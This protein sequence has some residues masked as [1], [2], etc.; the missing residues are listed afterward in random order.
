MSLVLVGV[1]AAAVLQAQVAKDA[2]PK[3][4]DGT[5]P[6][7][8]L[9]PTT[10]VIGASIDAA[11]DPAVDSCG[12]WNLE[13]PMQLRWSGSDATSGLAG[14][15]V[16]VFGPGWDY[17]T[18]NELEHGIS[19]T[20]YRFN[21]SNYDSDCGGGARDDEYWVV[22][23]DNRG[24]SARS[25]SFGQRI[26]VWQENGYNAASGE[27]GADGL[28]L[29]S[30]SGTWTRSNCTCFNGGHTLFSTSAGAALTYT[31]KV[32]RPGQTIGLAM[33]KNTNRGKADISVD[34]G[35]ATSVDTYASAA[36]HRVIVWQK[37]LS[38][39]THTIKVTNAGTAGRSRID[40]D[41]LLGS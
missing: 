13:V 39:G 5:S 32:T 28:R 29:S 9:K 18:G 17:P 4:Y 1:P 19:A 41:S 34:G 26:A 23:R 35:A 33:E 2:N 31:V 14:Y 36:R 37:T 38:V 3:V 7:L 10:F 21:G 16:W 15:D 24:N 25:M 27:I 20:S 22:A 12:L 30:R 40:V 6:A 8:T 11:G